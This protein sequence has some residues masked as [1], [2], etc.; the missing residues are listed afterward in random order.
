MN[1]I[2]KIEDLLIKFELIILIIMLGTMVLLAFL[3]VVLRNIFSTGFLWAD[4]FLRYL[5]VWVG[6]LGASIAAK[7]EKHINIDALSRFLKP[8]LQNIAS[9][10]T[11]GVAAVVCYYMFT[12]SIQFIQIGIP[13]GTTLF[14]NIS[15]IYF[16]III[17]AGFLLMAL[18]F[19]LRVVFKTYKAFQKPEVT[20]GAN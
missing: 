15:I 10:I 17:P 5:V 18:H 20:G 9:I 1:I 12:A 7:E 14:N 4:T 11:N 6:F 13:E 2:K 19:G 3:Q 8:T 16:I